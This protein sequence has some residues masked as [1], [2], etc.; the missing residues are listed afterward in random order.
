MHRCLTTPATRR[1]CIRAS[2]TAVRTAG[3]SAVDATDA[4]AHGRIPRER[5]VRGTLGPAQGTTIATT[6]GAWLAA[7]AVHGE[8]HQYGEDCPQDRAHV[9]GGARRGLGHHPHAERVV[10]HRPGGVCLSRLEPLAG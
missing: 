5:G 4:H 9:E 7:V 10:G 2:A 1:S 3:S 8:Y 6:S